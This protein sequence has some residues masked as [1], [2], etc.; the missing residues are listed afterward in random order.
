MDIAARQRVSTSHPLS[1]P[2]HTEFSPKGDALAVK[3][4][5]GRIVVINPS[6]AQVLHDHENQ[7]EGEGSG[8][9][10]S[11]DGDGLVDGSWNGVLTVRRARD[12]EILS[13]E[14]LPGE[15]I[16]RVTHDSSRRIWLVEHSP[17]VRPRENSP[18]PDYLTVRRW[19]FLPETMRTFSLGARWIGSSTLSPDGS[20]FCFIERSREHRVHI[21][22]TS[23][24]EILTSSLPLMAGGTGH[25]LAWSA[26]GRYIAA[27]SDSVFVIFGSNDLA[28]VG[29]IACQYPSSMVFLPGGG[30]L[31]LGSWKTT[32]IVKFDDAIRGSAPA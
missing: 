14:S 5:S 1:H 25:E 8:V 23:D 29:R 10:F 17:K 31:A 20:R 13:R 27:V 6:S 18:P 21:A 15:M 28:V 32:T 12:S 22:Q 26:D 2:S 16:T 9:S 19:P 4:T 11:P 30:D 3:S 24:G 7:R